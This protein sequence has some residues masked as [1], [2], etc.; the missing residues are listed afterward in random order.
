[1]ANY[2]LSNADDILNLGSMSYLRTG[3]APQSGDSGNGLDGN[4]TIIGANYND[5][6]AGG[7]G[8]DHLSGG[9]G[10]DTLIGGAGND[11]LM[12]GAGN[13][14]F[15][16]RAADFSS[17]LLSVKTIY[18]FGGAAGDILADRPSYVAGDNDFL[19]FT[20]FGAGST[21]TFAKDSTVQSNVAYYTLHDGAEG[22]NYTIAIKSDNGAHIGVGD[23]NFYK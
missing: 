15:V 16:F 19:R 18:D 17:S 8:D 3:V 10:N 12:G 7:S 2:I 4:D 21:F 13:D 20:G 9:S 23:F 1:M 22:T 14:T 5:L 6:I 11:Y